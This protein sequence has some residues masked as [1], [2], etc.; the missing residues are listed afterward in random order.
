MLILVAIILA[1]IS[2]MKVRAST[3]IENMKTFLDSQIPGINVQVNATAETQPN[4]NITIMLSL[5]RQTGIY[6]EHFNLSI[7][8]Y[9]NGTYEIL[10]CNIT[11][12]GFFL[13]DSPRSYNYTFT[14][15]VQ[16]WDTTYGEIM[17][18]YN[19]T[20]PVGQG[21]LELPYNIA[22]GFAMTHV[23]NVYLKD[24]ESSYLQLQQS[25]TALQQNYTALQSSLAELDNT[26]TAVAVLA[27]ASV[28]FVVTT[29]YLIVRKPKEYY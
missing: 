25:Y 3:S 12:N 4:Q 26:R 14:V 23:E 1:S 27:A 10:M 21:S 13:G 15:P 5:K 24:L 17:L 8:G 9:V 28:F 16:V 20:Y 18:A 11:D 29:V 19:A 2:N 6:V 22:L 7:F